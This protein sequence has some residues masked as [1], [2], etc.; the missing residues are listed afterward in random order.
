MQNWTSFA[1]SLAFFM[2]SSGAAWAQPAFVEAPD[3]MFVSLDT[4]S[5]GGGVEAS[6]SV[7]NPTE[8][9]MTLMVT[10]ILLD[11]VSP[12]NY[13]YQSGAE[14]A[15]E[16]FCWGATCFGYG[17][18]SSPTNPAFLVTLEPGDTN[19]TFYS[20]YYP[21]NVIGTSTIR[22]CF[23]PVGSVSQGA[24]RNMTFVA[25]GTAA[26]EDER[27]REFSEVWSLAP[28]PATD[29][30]TVTWDY[31]KTGVLEFRNL[32]GQVMRSEQVFGGVSSQNVSLS[33]LAQGIWLVSYKVDGH[34][35]STKRL[36][37]R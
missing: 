36:V 23:H 21:N 18:D 10:R 26:L 5:Q 1:A 9:A 30:V 34:V 33:G 11:T 14:G 8:E 22:Y 35:L 2:F 29:M 15:Y 19:H 6:W 12:F 20:D 7:T 4:L 24:C 16:R 32:V 31:T 25:D 27:P 3:T 13:P 37:I 28:N 17:T